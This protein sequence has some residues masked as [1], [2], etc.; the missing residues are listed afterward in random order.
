MVQGSREGLGVREGLFP[1]EP[2]VGDQ[3]GEG[4]VDV[5]FPAHAGFEADIVALKN[6]FCRRIWCLAN[7]YHLVQKGKTPPCV[8]S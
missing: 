4:G 3:E 2:L 1:A 7:T 6:L 5:A 8:F